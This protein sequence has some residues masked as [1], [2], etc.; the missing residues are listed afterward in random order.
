MLVFIGLPLYELPKEV[1]TANVHH[2]VSFKNTN[3]LSFDLKIARPLQI[4]LTLLVEL[5]T[6]KYT[7]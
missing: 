4:S 1:C 7:Q 5:L 3:L 2:V 6:C